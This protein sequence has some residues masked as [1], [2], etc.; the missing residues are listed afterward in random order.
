[1]ITLSSSPHDSVYGASPGADPHPFEVE[2][3]DLEADDVEE[4]L[5]EMEPFALDL[6][7]ADD[8]ALDLVLADLAAALVLDALAEISD[9]AARDMEL[10]LGEETGIRE[11]V[12]DTFEGEAVGETDDWGL[13]GLATEDDFDDTAE[14]RELDDGLVFFPVDMAEEEADEPLFPAAE[15]TLEPCI[16][17]MISPD[18]DFG[19]HLTRLSLSTF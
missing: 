4:A 13:A 19:T 3:F 7:A 2:G 17:S 16:I 1:M 10:T 5:L 18:T 15:D 11:A 8:L 9:L 12:L 14:A 6:A